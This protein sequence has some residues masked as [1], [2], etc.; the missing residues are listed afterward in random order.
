MSEVI[1]RGLHRAGAGTRV[2]DLPGAIGRLPG[3]ADARCAGQAWFHEH[4]RADGV[5]VRGST[6]PDTSKS[7]TCQAVFRSH[8]SADPA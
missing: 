1:G 5:G 4:A 6:E 3:I 2:A 7:N 8:I